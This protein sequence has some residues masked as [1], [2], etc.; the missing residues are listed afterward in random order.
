MLV[1]SDE[2]THPPS[3][4]SS[5]TQSVSSYGTVICDDDI[6][7]VG[8]KTEFNNT[9]I[10]E[11]NMDQDGFTRALGKKKQK[12]W[13]EDHKEKDQEPKEPQSEN[14]D[15]VTPYRQLMQPSKKG[16]LKSPKRIS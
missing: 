12:G 13:K 5:R 3:S 15:L 11:V 7:I 4:S 1:N 2:L 8:D 9:E 14:R 16:S 6:A 10:F